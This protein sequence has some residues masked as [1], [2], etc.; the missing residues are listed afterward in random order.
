MTTKTAERATKDW[1]CA[2]CE[3]TVSWMP[4]AERP[5]LPGTWVKEKGEFYCLACRRDRAAEAGLAG[6]AEDTP[7]AERQQ[8]R[9]EALVEFEVKRTPERPDN[10]IANACH[11]SMASVRKARVR[12][13]MKSPIRR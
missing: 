5:M 7:I 1:T 8:L 2:G 9:S 4:D 11:M 10:R 6:M 3:M 12:L 13:G